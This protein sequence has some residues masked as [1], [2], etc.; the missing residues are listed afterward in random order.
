MYG[1]GLVH[2]QKSQLTET[3]WSTYLLAIKTDHLQYNSLL[4]ADKHIV[5]GNTQAML[6]GCPQNAP[7]EPVSNTL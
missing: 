5:M 2:W 1:P 6:P 4:Q 3:L 7:Q